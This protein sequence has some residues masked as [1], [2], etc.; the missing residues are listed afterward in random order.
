MTEGE[1]KDQTLTSSKDC[2]VTVTKAFLRN[3]DQITTSHSYR[4]IKNTQF[5]EQ[6]WDYG[7]ASISLSYREQLS[8][9]ES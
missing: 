7:N 8:W 6:K 1:I 5:R 2:E 3:T 4:L 9:D